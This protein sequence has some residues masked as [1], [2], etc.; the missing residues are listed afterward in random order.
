L[1]WAHVQ[2]TA[3]GNSGGA[4]N[5]VSVMYG[6][7][8]TVGNL[9]IC[10]L[11]GEDTNG[12]AET[13]SISDGTNTWTQAALINTTGSG[14][15]YFSGIWYRVFTASAT[16]TL[17]ASVG[18]S[19]AAYPAISVDEYSFSPGTISVPASSTG[20][21]A[22]SNTFTTGSLTIGNGTNLVIMTV[23]YDGTGTFAAGS[24]FT[25]RETVA[26]SSG[27]NVAIC[28]EDKFNATS[29]I[30]PAMSLTG[31]TSIWRAAAAA[32]VSSGDGGIS[33]YPAALLSAM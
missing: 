12:V 22:L 18:G 13:I 23:N 28:T 25:L 30:T 9:G 3:A 4:G 27:H 5:G 31:S 7:A 1:S 2:G 24:G 11:S 8:V 6:S 17:T 10:C 26:Y 16:F 29:P 19:A 32:F 15:F 33:I 21:A 14:G 20:S